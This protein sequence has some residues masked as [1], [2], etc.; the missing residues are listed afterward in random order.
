VRPLFPEAWV[1]LAYQPP[2]VAF[3]LSLAGALLLALINRRRFVGAASVAALVLAL[4]LVFGVRMVTPRML[5]ERLPWLVAAFGLAGLVGD[6][7]GLRRGAVALLAAAASLGGVWFMLGAPRATPDLARVV[8]EALPILAAFA[9]PMWRLVAD[10]EGPGGAGAA[11][12]AAGLLGL[13]LWLAGGA[14]VFVGLAVTVCAAALGA[15]GAA[16]LLRGAGLGLAGAFGLAAGIGGT[17][18]AQG[19]AQRGPAVWLACAAPLVGLLLWA[20]AARW[21]GLGGDGA[22]QAFLAVAAGGLPLIGL[23][24]LVRMGG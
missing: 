7:L 20:R 3:A 11:A 24:W 4:F 22:A 9:V 16:M 1:A 8:A 14:T 15:A 5:P 23:A 17:A 18:A 10:R 12:S 2:L 19:L 21:V 6:L 13:G